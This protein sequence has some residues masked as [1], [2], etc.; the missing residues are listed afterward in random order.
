MKNFHW[1]PA[2]GHLFLIAFPSRKFGKVFIYAG[3]WFLA[4][5]NG[6]FGQLPGLLSIKLAWSWKR[7]LRH[8]WHF[9]P[10]EVEVSKSLG[11]ML[12]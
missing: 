2:P 11:W 10:D 6:Y 9:R 5:D 12:R 1:R 4:A 8:A 3:K 7:G